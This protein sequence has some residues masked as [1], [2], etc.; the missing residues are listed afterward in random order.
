MH[1]TT[2]C[3]L[4][5]HVLTRFNHPL[6]RMSPPVKLTHQISRRS[7]Q[8]FFSPLILTIPLQSH[9]LNDKES[10][11][12]HITV[13]TIFNIFAPLPLTSLALTRAIFWVGELSTFSTRVVATWRPPNNVPRHRNRVSLLPHLEQ[14]EGWTSHP[15]ATRCWLLGR[16]LFM[17]EIRSTESYSDRE[18]I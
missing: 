14:E 16:L 12:Y 11:S 18:E 4:P 6:Q 7:S 9:T 15:L 10:P 3:P 17:P 2:A 8:R 5:I 13:C 1:F